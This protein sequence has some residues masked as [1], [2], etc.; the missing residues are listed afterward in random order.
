M[1]QFFRDTS[2]L[3]PQQGAAVYSRYGMKLIGPPL[4]QS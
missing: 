2:A 3:G 1:E 4:S